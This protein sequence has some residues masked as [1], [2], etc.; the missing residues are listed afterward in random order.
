[1][2]HRSLGDS[3]AIV[4]LPDSAGIAQ[5]ARGDAVSPP[6]LDRLFPA[7]IYVAGGAGSVSN[8]PLLPLECFRLR[9]LASSAAGGGSQQADPGAASTAADEQNVEGDW[10]TH[11]MLKR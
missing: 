2:D 8:R 7:S 6:E 11:V 4:H 10:V 1:M 5:A 9:L 3:E